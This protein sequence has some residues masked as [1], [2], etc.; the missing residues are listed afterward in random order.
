MALQ[1]DGIAANP[2]RP[3]LTV[4]AARSGH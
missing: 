4:D 3:V 2:G 1:A